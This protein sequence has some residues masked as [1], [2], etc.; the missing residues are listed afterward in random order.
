MLTMLFSLFLAMLPYRQTGNDIERLC[1][2]GGYFIINWKT[3]PLLICE[4]QNPTYV[5][6]LLNPLDTEI[7]FGNFPLR[8]W[9][10][11]N[12]YVDLPRCWSK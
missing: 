3:S 5:C 8:T 6:Y 10:G 12:W 11:D 2:D 4:C 9:S 1:I 7:R